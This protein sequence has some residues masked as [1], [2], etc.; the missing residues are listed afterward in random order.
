EKAPAELDS[1]L[2][3][4]TKLANA[5]MQELLALAR[6]LRPTALDDLGLEAAI[7]GQVKDLARHSELEA[8]F[9]SEGEFGALD[10]DAQLVLYRVAQE[11]LSNAQRHS[12]AKV[13]RAELRR[14]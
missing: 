11:A 13:V 6:Q 2:A 4:T 12:G 7:A 10:E 14:R 1:E 3:E 8:S 5:A 9:A